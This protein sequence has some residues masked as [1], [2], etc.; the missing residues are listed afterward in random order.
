M[1]AALCACASEERKRAE[2]FAPKETHSQIAKQKKR[3]VQPPFSIPEAENEICE[4]GVQ[5]F[6]HDAAAELK[7]APELV[8]LGFMEDRV[9][10]GAAFLNR[11]A[12]KKLRVL[13][14]SAATRSPQN[15]MVEE[16]T[17]KRGVV[18]IIRRID[19][20]DFDHVRVPCLW[21]AEGSKELVFSYQLA[22]KGT[23]WSV[24]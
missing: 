3:P 4:P 19:W 6:A 21:V 24:K 5:R 9:D 13:S 14:L 22:R 11:F 7:T 16:Q 12:S 10:P 2:F 18:L 1:V 17:G 20:L 15:F 8:F 23:K